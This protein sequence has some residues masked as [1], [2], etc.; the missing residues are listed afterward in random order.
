MAALNQS[1]LRACEAIGCAE[2]VSEG[3]LFCER[4][5]AM[6]QSD[7]KQILAKKWRP[8]RKPTKV[9]SVVLERARKEV[10]FCQ[11]AGYRTPRDA[12]FEW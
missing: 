6:L 12:E 1:T 2:L 10:L 9:F 8:G 11:Q 4:H 7:V 5:D 3:Q